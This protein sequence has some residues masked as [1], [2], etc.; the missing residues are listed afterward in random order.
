MHKSNA[1]TAA[2]CLAP[3]TKA[4]DLQEIIDALMD[5]LQ[6]LD[7]GLG[8]IGAALNRLGATDFPRDAGTSSVGGQDGHAIGRLRAVVCSLRAKRIEAD[9]LA[10][11]LSQTI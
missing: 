1:P 4:S 10:D 7:A 3:T 5:E 8:R 2:G 11:R 6:Q 9:L